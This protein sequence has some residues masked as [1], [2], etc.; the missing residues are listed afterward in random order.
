ML[1]KDLIEQ[2]KEILERQGDHVRVP[3][4]RITYNGISGILYLDESTSSYR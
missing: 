1:L 2:L 3:E 4:Y